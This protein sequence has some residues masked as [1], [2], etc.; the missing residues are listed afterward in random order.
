MPRVYGAT[1]RRPDGLEAVF[2]RLGRGCPPRDS[3]EDPAVPIRF[4]GKQSSTTHDLHRE[5]GSR[6]RHELPAS[7]HRGRAGSRTLAAMTTGRPLDELTPRSTASRNLHQ[8]PYARG[9]FV[10]DYQ[11]LDSQGTAFRPFFTL[12]NPGSDTAFPNPKPTDEFIN[13]PSEQPRPAPP[14][15]LW[16]S[17]RRP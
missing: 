8:A 1:R 14:A 3:S 9:Y 6:Q 11:G 16:A 10:G 13:K 15:L 12:A 17:A 2:R 4:I 5:I 7:D